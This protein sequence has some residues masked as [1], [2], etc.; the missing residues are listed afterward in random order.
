M[1]QMGSPISVEVREGHRRALGYDTKQ[2]R[3]A[4]EGYAFISPG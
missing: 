3:R 2:L 4:L 1:D